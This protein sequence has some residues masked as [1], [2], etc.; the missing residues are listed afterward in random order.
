MDARVEN[1]VNYSTVGALAPL[2]AGWERPMQVAVEP[3]CDRSHHRH[4]GRFRL[5]P[6][7]ERMADVG[8]Q[9]SPRRLRTFF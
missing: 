9:A 5:S 2:G 1:E 4:P 3:Y 6:R 7:L 8:Q